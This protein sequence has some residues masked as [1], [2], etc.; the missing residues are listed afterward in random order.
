MGDYYLPE[1]LASKLG[2]TLAELEQAQARGLIQP[3]RKN[4]L[5]FYSSQHAYKLRAASRLRREKGLSWDEAAAELR[6][7]PLYQVASR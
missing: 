3:V 7:R 1:Q 6:K 5:V 2:L 4:G